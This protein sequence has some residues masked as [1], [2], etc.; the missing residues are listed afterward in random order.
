MLIDLR[1]VKLRTEILDKIRYR[2]HDKNPKAEIILFGSRARGNFSKDS[3]WDILILL[4]N[5][6]VDRKEEMIYRDIIFDIELETE[7]TISTF[8]YSK[9]KWYNKHVET[10]F[11]KNVERDGILLK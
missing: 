2:I 5:I 1:I 11:Y 4:D 8:I 7:Q 9:E 3:D 6:F 10:P